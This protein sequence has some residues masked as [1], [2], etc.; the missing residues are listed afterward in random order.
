MRW[1]WQA[2]TARGVIL[3]AAICGVARLPPNQPKAHSAL[4]ASL[5]PRAATMLTIAMSLTIAAAIAARAQG[6]DDIGALNRQVVQKLTVRGNTP[7][8][9]PSPSR[10]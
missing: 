3:A 6:A 10:S 4:P 7:R 1:I 9:Q 5:M 8:R 2:L